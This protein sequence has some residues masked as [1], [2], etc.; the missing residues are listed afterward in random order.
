MSQGVRAAA[1]DSIETVFDI[2]P[3]RGY[4]QQVGLPPNLLEPWYTRFLRD[5][6]AL[7]AMERYAPMADVAAAALRELAAEHG[8]SIAQSQAEAVLAGFSQ[9]PAH[10]D[11]RPAFA[12]LK[13]A[14]VAV[15]LLSN[16]SKAVLSKLVER[17]GLGDVIDHV[18]SIDDVKAWKPRAVVYQHAAKTFGVPINQVAM[19]AAH[20]WD[21]FGGQSAGMIS[22]WRPRRRAEYNPMMGKP[23]VIGATLV[24]VAEKLI[25]ATAIEKR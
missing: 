24:E 8:Y 2:E 17:A 19:V 9:M 25:G 13:Q 18:M 21:C 1:F 5:G 6:V 11:A 4:L 22:A 20:A 12:R 7:A 3:L 16:G 23:D 15:G 10:A 14:G